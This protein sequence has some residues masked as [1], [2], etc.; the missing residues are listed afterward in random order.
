ML[1]LLLH[2]ALVHEL[3]DV[4]K[5]VVLP[6]VG[7]GLTKRTSHGDVVGE[8]R[9]KATIKVGILCL[10]VC[11]QTTVLHRQV[12]IFFLVHLLVDD[13]SLCNAERSAGAALMDL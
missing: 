6:R 12:V 5:L 4:V 3:A 10:Q 9:C 13:V 8:V 2:R 7:N 1:L 11:S